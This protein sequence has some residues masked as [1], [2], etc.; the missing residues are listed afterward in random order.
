MTNLKMSSIPACHNK[1]NV[2]I[3]SSVI[4]YAFHVMLL[5]EFLHNMALFIDLFV[6]ANI[7]MLDI[8]ATDI[9]DIF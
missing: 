4:S 2:S 9:I 5:S 6:G 1:H 7:M 3:K 8:Y